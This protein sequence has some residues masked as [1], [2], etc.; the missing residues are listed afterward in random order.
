[1]APQDGPW[2]P[3]AGAPDAAPDETGRET[4][5]AGPQKPFLPE[6][7]P[8]DLGQPSKPTTPNDR[9]GPWVA[10][11]REPRHSGANF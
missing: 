7:P 4:I 8:I 9:S 10:A 2:G 3:H 11:R 5:P 6:R 1:M